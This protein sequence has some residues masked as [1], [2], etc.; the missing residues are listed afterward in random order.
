M[1]HFASLIALLS[2]A[3][4]W[5][6]RANEQ[7]VT[8]RNV[9]GPASFQTKVNLVLVPVVVRDVKGNPIGT[10]RR[11]DFELF[12]NNKPQPI[13]KFSVEK[14][15]SRKVEFE[16]EVADAPP[17]ETPPAESPL[18]LADR[19]TALLFDDLNNQMSHTLWA[20]KAAEKYIAEGLPPAE[21]MAIYTTSATVTQELT[22][23]QEKLLEA[24]RAIK[25]V[26]MLRPRRVLCPDLSYTWALMTQTDPA[27]YQAAFREAADC[28]HLDTSPTQ[29]EMTRELVGRAISQALVS[30]PEISRQNL[31]RIE[32]VIRMLA[33]MPGERNLLLVS[34][35]FSMPADQKS[36]LGRLIELAI[37]NRVTISSLDV[38]GLE[39]GALGRGAGYSRIAAI[40]MAEVLQDVA[41][42]TGGA[43]V[44][45]TNDFTGGFRKLTMAPEY[46]Y[47]LG[48]SP[49]SLKL[50]GSLHRLKVR[51]KDGRMFTVQARL[52]YY[53]PK[54]LA[55]PKEEEKKEIREALFS[56]DALHDLPVELRTQYFKSGEIDA[57][58]SILAKIDVGQIRFRKDG[59]LNFDNLTVAAALFDA[60]GNL[61]T[62]ESK[63]VELKLRDETLKDKVRSIL[64]IKT[65]FDVKTGGYV[66]R[67][68]VRDSV[69]QFMAAL[70]GSLVI[71]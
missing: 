59:G 9:E 63:L 68:V 70:N 4:A 23:D 11:E 54:Q 64:T 60:S 2:V 53:A 65:N 38:R 28:G 37:R 43:I 49:Q 34:S 21:R 46:T 24:L 41:H 27:A 15:G 20:R 31:I 35:G 19:Y 26:N 66:V 10:L 30:G 32:A 18:V 40:D 16:P 50:D 6:A 7:E 71:P 13:V 25:P 17:G 33:R 42:G 8:T 36:E 51:V 29:I 14:A 67:L 12:D 62:A 52:G 39:I 3:L 61:V 45:S 1:S 48:F 57:K 56:R 22:S 58:V 55:D 69:G 47:I 44:E 5:P